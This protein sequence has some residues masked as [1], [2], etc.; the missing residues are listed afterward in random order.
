MIRF[1]SLFAFASSFALLVA[2]GEDKASVEGPSQSAAPPTFDSPDS[3]VGSPLGTLGPESGDLAL[4]EILPAPSPLPPPVEIPPDWAT[5]TSTG[6]VRFNFRYPSAWYSVGQS[7]V[8]KY[9]PDTWRYSFHP[10]ETFVVGVGVAGPDSIPPAS[11]PEDA[12]N[13]ALGGLPAHQYLGKYDPTKFGNVTQIHSVVV[14]KD[15]YR[16]GVSGTST[17][18]APDQATFLLILSSFVF[19]D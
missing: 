2:C 7:G 13:T 9:D 16:I 19:A 18:A 17:Q 11:T 10:R 14:G 12:P 6:P 5:F 1:Q 3:S 8:Q 15:G 4:L